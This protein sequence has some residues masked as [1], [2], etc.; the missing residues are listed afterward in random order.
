[1]AVDFWILDFIQMYLRNSFLDTVMPLVTKLG[2]GGIFWIVS[3]LV[4]LVIPK[5]RKVGCVV[6]AALIIEA[7]CCNVI[8]KPLVARTRPF[9]INVD[10]NLLIAP[11]KD[12]SFPSGH[13]GASF[14]AASAM[15]FARKYLEKSWNWLWIT[16]FITA[17]VIAYSR[18][19][20]YVHY[21][22]DVL[23]GLVFGIVSAW[24][25]SL[26]VSSIMNRTKKQPP[27][28]AL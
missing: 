27:Q 20:L 15:Y 28:S 7:L 16:A 2:D 11:P 25:A 8:V 13:T 9:A 3:G 21:P 22:T 14:A 12:F 18:L 6:A 17:T 24:I 5:T 10:I 23:A 19:Y 26:A 4:L 1:M